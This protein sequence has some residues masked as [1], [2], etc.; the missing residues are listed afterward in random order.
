MEA[1]IASIQADAQQKRSIADFATS[2][3]SELASLEGAPEKELTRELL[4]QGLHRALDLG[5]TELRAKFLE[6][7]TANIHKFPLQEQA[8]LSRAYPVEI[9]SEYRNLRSFVD[10]EEIADS[11][12]AVPDAP[13]TAATAGTGPLSVLDE[14]RGRLAALPTKPGAGAEEMLQRLQ[15]EE[16]VQ[17]LRGREQAQRLRF[18]SDVRLNLF[19][20]GEQGQRLLVERFQELRDEVARLVEIMTQGVS[21][22]LE[23]EKLSPQQPAPAP[24][25][26]KLRDLLSA[27]LSAPFLATFRHLGTGEKQ[28]KEAFLLKVALCLRTCQERSF[29]DT[30]ELGDKV[31]ALRR[32]FFYVEGYGEL[33]EEWLQQR[34]RQFNEDFIN[35]A[36]IAVET[37]FGGVLARLRRTFRPGKWLPLGSPR[38]EAEIVGIFL[39]DADTF[40]RHV[41]TTASVT[42]MLRKVSS[43]GGPDF[44]IYS[45]IAR[46]PPIKATRAAGSPPQDQVE[47][48]LLELLHRFP[49]FPALRRSRPGV[50]WFGRCEVDFSLR[51]QGAFMARILQ[52]PGASQESTAEEFFA[53]AGCEEYP[54]AATL[55]VQA[56]EQSPTGPPSTGI[57]APSTHLVLVPPPPPAFSTCP[58]AI[59]QVGA[60]PGQPP[61]P[62]GF[63][64]MPSL[65]AAMTEPSLQLVTSFPGSAPLASTMPAPCA[66]LAP[67]PPLTSPLLGTFTSAFAAVPTA[68]NGGARYE[69]YP[70]TAP[71]GVPSFSGT[72][73]TGMAGGV[74]QPPQPAA[75]KFGLD[76]DEI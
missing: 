36:S 73:P 38:H 20:F 64:S 41:V 31:A 75:G 53:R 7:L 61:P 68:T 39:D 25:L 17:A 9:S 15:G 40:P 33:M 70:A 43:H 76:D 4:A 72:V 5:G 59:Q 22:W 58:G 21:Q 19:K 46:L 47:S 2:L 49:P 63:P 67:L 37:S 28:K 1:R 34:I 16:I 30:K 18:F 48:V 35:R 12:D 55:A 50:F 74:L 10:V 6:A 44:H 45:E 13:A 51:S 66:A 23:Q 56:S 26:T 8:S 29:N 71:E 60:L 32:Q 24:L 11:P 57:E 62:A 14:V 69:P 3:V 54:T 42:S 27:I 52:G 65:P